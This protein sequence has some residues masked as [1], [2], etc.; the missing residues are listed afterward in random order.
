MGIAMKLW[1]RHRYANEICVNKARFF[2]RMVN[3]DG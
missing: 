1:Q 2:G 3:S